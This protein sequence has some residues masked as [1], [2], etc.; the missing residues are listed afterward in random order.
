[1]HNYAVMI[2]EEDGDVDMDLP[3]NKKLTLS[4]AS[5]FIL[6]FPPFL[7]QLLRGMTISQSSDLDTLALL[8]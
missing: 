2:S 3:R 8:R 1:M 5:G 4:D 7:A 6:Y